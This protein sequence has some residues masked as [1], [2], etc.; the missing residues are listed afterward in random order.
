MAG[1]FPR[2]PRRDQSHTPSR[3]GPPVHDI[4][5]HEGVSLPGGYLGGLQKVTGHRIGIHCRRWE[6]G[7][8]TQLVGLGTGRVGS[9]IGVAEVRRC[10]I[11]LEIDVGG[12]WLPIF[13]LCDRGFASATGEGAALARAAG[14]VCLRLVLTFCIGAYFLY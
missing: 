13:R 9:L 12:L 14:C 6:P 4:A 11:A 3:P 7:G 2:M 1:K 5:V 10:V 8:D